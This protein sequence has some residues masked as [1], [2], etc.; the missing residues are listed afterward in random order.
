MGLWYES[1]AVVPVE[2]PQYFDLNPTY[3]QFVMLLYI[4]VICYD[5]ITYIYVEYGP[6]TFEII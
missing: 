2:N 4:Y 3:D 5:M 6:Q 1:V